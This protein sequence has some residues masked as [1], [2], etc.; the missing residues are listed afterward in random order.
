MNN[1]QIIINII[2]FDE[3]KMIKKFKINFKYNLFFKF[4][5]SAKRRIQ[6]F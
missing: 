1:N 4:K 2:I 5:K 3:L 6:K